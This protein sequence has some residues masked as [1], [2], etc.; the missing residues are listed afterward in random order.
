VKINTDA[1]FCSDTGEASAGVVIRDD[2]GV[3]IL[4]AWQM[5]NRCS[6]PEAAEAEATLWG[7]RLRPEWVRKPVVIEVDY[8]N[9]VQ[10][11]HAQTEDRAEGAGVQKEIKAVCS[12]LP[13]C[14][15][16]FARRS[17]NRVAHSLAQHALHTKECEV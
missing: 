6:S 3:V 15:F 2:R 8:A 5:L 13:E 4:V 7:A 10:N 11:L 9:I 1:G 17:A 14:R 16:Q 12:L